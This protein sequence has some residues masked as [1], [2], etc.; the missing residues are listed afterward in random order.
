MNLLG[1]DSYA[2][3][4][5]GKKKAINISMSWL[6]WSLTFSSLGLRVRCLRKISEK[7]K[8]LPSGT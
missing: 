5:S 8:F 4:V 2:R 1:L 3:G 7:C 6:D